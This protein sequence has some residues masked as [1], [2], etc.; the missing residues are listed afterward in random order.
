MGALVAAQVLK[1]CQI[2]D[3][4]DTS[5]NT[6]ALAT[7][8][9]YTK[10]GTADGKFTAQRQLDIYNDARMVAAYVIS[11]KKGLRE[12][13]EASNNTIRKT[14]A[15][16]A[17]GVLAKPTGYI[18]AKS[19]LDVNGKVISIL[20]VDQIPYTKRLD[21]L[22]N[23]VVYEETANFR[24]E[25]GATYIP[26]AATYVLRY[27]GI[28][29]FILTDVTGQATTETFSPFYEPFL[30]Q[31]AVAIAQQQGQVKALALAEQLLGGQA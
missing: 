29:P 23:P 13:Q 28:T 18:Y 31:I 15:T 30:I 22:N 14:D 24:S 16:F 7:S 2:V 3:P 25:N 12:R 17:T 5:D 19:L 6:F 9:G 1:M 20:P 26:D 4:R 21:S 8:T 10:I 27:I 11:Y